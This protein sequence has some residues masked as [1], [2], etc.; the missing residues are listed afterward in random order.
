M[1]AKSQVSFTADQVLAACLA[2]DNEDNDYYDDQTSDD[3]FIEDFVDEDGEKLFF[4]AECTACFVPDP[5][6][7]DSLLIDNVSILAIIMITFHSLAMNYF[8]I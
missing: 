4:P 8:N 6:D 3:S 2:S 5:S 7:R 1:A